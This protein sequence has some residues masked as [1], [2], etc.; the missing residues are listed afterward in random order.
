MA[1]VYAAKRN[2][3]LHIQKINIVAHILLHVR[4]LKNIDLVKLIIVSP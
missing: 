1:A 4:K 2:A 3:V